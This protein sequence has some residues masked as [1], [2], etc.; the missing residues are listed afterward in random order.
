MDSTP[1]VNVTVAVVSPGAAADGT[2][3]TSASAQIVVAD[4]RKVDFMKHLN[5]GS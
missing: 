5:A 3:E 4:M 1:P 2:A